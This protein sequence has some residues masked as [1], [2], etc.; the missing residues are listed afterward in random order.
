VD[1]RLPIGHYALVADAVVEDADGWSLISQER[2]IDQIQLDFRFGL[3]LDDGTLIVIESPF[4]VS[5]DGVVTN[6]VPETLEHVGPALAFLHHDVSNV[7][8][9]RSG[10][11][12][13]VL[14]D[15]AR[16]DVSPGDGY[17]NRAICAHG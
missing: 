1:S 13:I 6:A 5:I 11:L 17:E 16:I 3:M 14:S 8:A 12:H 10:A 15:G 9:L 2:R 4:V 7:H